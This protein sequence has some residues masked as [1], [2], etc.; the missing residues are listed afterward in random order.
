MG[1]R[2]CLRPALN[3]LRSGKTRGQLRFE[4]DEVTMTI[5]PLPEEVTLLNVQPLAAIEGGRITIACRNVDMGAF[6]KTRLKV[7]GVVTRVDF[8]R[9]DLLIAKVPLGAVS[10]MITLQ[11][12]GHESNG[13]PCEVGA[14]NRGRFTNQ[15]ASHEIQAGS[16]SRLGG[17]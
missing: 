5:E 11:V 15:R 6:A 1:L 8:A 13:I 12:N 9:A 16:H 4:P 17:S 7:G 14:Y 2:H 10:G 3:R